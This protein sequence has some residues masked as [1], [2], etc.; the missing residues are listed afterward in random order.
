MATKNQET[1]IITPPNIQVFAVE[2]ESQSP[3]LCHRFDEKSRRA[4]QTS[5]GNK[6]APKQAV[7]PDDEY[8]RSLY[9]MEDGRYG[10]PVSGFKSAMVR[11]AKHIHGLSMTDAR[12]MFFVIPDGRD[13]LGTDLVAISGE[14]QRRDDYVR[15]GQGTSMRYRGEFPKWTAILRVSHDADL[16][17]RESIASLIARAGMTVGI[18]DWRPEKSGSFGLFNIKSE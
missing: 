3:L 9:V 10:F 13:D 2:I 1:I 16:I 18:G 12:G 17:G 14:P 5:G 6:K 7:D 11:A 4:V 15:V 8:R